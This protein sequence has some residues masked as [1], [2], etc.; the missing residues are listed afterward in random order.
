MA[1]KAPQT[2]I[3]TRD[4]RT[5]RRSTA[6]NATIMLTVLRLFTEKYSSSGFFIS[7]PIPTAAHEDEKYEVI[8]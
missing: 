3:I 8:E 1:L 4:T 6:K 7:S 2:D 5:P